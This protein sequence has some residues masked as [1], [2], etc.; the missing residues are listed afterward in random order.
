MD[1]VANLLAD[2]S[3]PASSEQVLARLSAL[4][5]A[6]HTVEH[7]ALRTVAD[8]KRHRQDPNGGY[9]KNL[10]LRNKKGRMWL[11]TLH[12]DRVID[13]R[14]LGAHIG[15]GRISF[16]SP[17]RLMHYLGVVP[18]AVTPLAVINDRTRQVSAVIDSKLLQYDKLHFHPCDNSRTTTLSCDGLL[19]YMS[20]CGHPPQQIDFDEFALATAKP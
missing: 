14:R 1:N 2:G 13:L 18:G 6:H 16:A 9:S 8:S 3:V 17:Q 15:A 20:D 11:V 7:P 5:V 12:E 19:R 10:F 4:D